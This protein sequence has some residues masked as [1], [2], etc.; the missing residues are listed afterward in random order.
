MKKDIQRN[1]NGFNDKFEI[2]DPV[3]FPGRE[4]K[5]SSPLGYLKDQSLLVC[6]KRL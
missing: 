5:S 6:E 4:P 1:I 2:A 3:K